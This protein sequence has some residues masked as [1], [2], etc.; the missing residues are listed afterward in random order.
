MMLV[1]PRIASSRTASKYEYADTPPNI[2]VCSTTSIKAAFLEFV[3]PPWKLPD[4]TVKTLPG[5]EDA[6]M[7]FFKLPWFCPA[8]PDQH[9]LHGRFFRWR[10]QASMAVEVSFMEVFKLPWRLPASP[11]R[12]LCGSRVH[13][14]SRGSMENAFQTKMPS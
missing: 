9:F 2:C 5:S 12:H 3:L 7:E 1:C 14:S 8:C 4:I 6:F 10:F 13:A 11:A